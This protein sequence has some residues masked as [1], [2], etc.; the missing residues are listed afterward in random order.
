LV[1]SATPGVA[2]WPRSP[3]GNLR[4]VR[5]G[6]VCPYSLTLVGGVQGQVLGLAR[7]LR[8]LGTEARVLAPCD[9]AP[10]EPFVT[11]LG[12][13]IPTV[14][15]GSLAP[16]APDPSAALRTVRALRDE[17]F[18]V[19]HIHEPL[20]PGPSLTSLVLASGPAIGTFH[21]SGGIAN[22]FVAIRPGA[23]WAVGHLAVRCAVSADAEKTARQALGG[24]YER[25]WNGIDCDMYAKTP[26]WPRPSGGPLV[27]FVGRHEPRKGL[28][29]LIDA[30]RQLGPDARLWVAGDGAQ[31]GRLVAA[32]RDDDRIE[33]LGVIGEAEKMARMRAADVVCA[34]SLGGESFGVVLLEG[35][36]ARTCVVASDVPGYREVARRGVEALLVPPGDPA[37]LSAAIRQVS[38]DEAT[39][40]RLIEAGACRAGHF[41]MTKLAQ[42]Y[43]GYYERAVACA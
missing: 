34:P 6:L 7:S 39:R 9:G 15:N 13:S 12:N 30:V 20:V 25:V 5:V 10:P 22:T 14:A 38:E 18:D 37:A 4:P 43:C 31:T 33:W 42:T 8:A 32:T 3:A 21:R 40:T 35:M 23:R 11:P 36:A 26:A 29:V 24:T 28:A 19:L 2:P 27:F 17:A 41:S 16:I 1:S